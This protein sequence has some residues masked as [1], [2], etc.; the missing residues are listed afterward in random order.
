MPAL[1]PSST[2]NLQQIV[3]LRGP[4]AE[5]LRGQMPEYLNLD[6][7]RGTRAAFSQRKATEFIEHFGLGLQCRDDGRMHDALEGLSLRTGP[8]TAG[9]LQEV[10]FFCFLILMNKLSNT[11]FSK[12]G[13]YTVVP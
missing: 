13:N 6:M 12:T 4:A 2:S 8:A 9:A 10:N 5:W 1:T 7:K 3:L 11:C